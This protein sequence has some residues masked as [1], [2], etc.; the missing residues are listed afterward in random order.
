MLGL[1]KLMTERGRQQAQTTYFYRIQEANDGKVAAITDARLVNHN[2]KSLQGCRTSSRLLLSSAQ[3][4]KKNKNN[5]EKR[6]IK[7]AE[8]TATTTT[9]T[10]TRARPGQAKPGQKHPDSWDFVRKDGGQ[11]RSR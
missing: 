7:D 4:R 10:T 9:T 3:R 5:K 11:T 6:T 1:L 2:N 8:T